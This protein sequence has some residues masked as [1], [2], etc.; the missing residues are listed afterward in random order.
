MRGHETS[1]FLSAFAIGAALG[2]GAVLLLRPDA[3]NPRR[4]LAK[5]LKPHAKKGKRGRRS[6]IAA[7]RLEG[8]AEEYLTGGGRAAAQLR[9]AALDMD[10]A[11]SAGRE[12]LAEFRAEVSRILVEA[13]EEL[14][15]I[16]A[17]EAPATAGVAEPAPADRDV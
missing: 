6:R 9:P 8:G 4:T 7:V 3:P 17:G 11:I 10:D 5:R 1:D 2:V 12:L 13:R 16:Q 15:L 14:Q